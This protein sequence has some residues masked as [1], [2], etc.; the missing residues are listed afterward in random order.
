MNILGL[1]SSRDSH[2]SSAA[3][4]CDGELVAAA[5]EERF[6]RKKHEPGLPA[7]AVKFCLERAGLRMAQVDVVAVAE[8][9]FRTGPSSYHAEMELSFMRRLCAEGKITKRSLVHKI[10]LDQCLSLGIGFNWQMSFAVA[11]SLAEFRE[12]YGDLPSTRF[13]DHHRAHAAAAY[14]TS[15]LDRAS[16]ATIDGY[17]GLCSSV[18]WVALGS[19]F[20]RMHAEPLHNSIG[21]F[22]WDCT[23]YLGLGDFDEG[24]TMGLASYG[25]GQAYARRLSSFLDTNC[26]GWYRY[27]GYLT[28]KLLGFP[29]R[30]SESILQ[31]P[32]PDFAAGAQHLLQRAI[33]KLVHST[34]GE[35]K[36]RA[37][38]LG[39]GV[40]LNCTSNGALLASG[41]PSSVWVFPATSDAGLSVGAAMLCAADA[42]ELRR[43]RMDNSYWGP[44]YSPAECEAAL[45]AA[46]GL[47]FRP[48]SGIASVVTD[49]LVAGNVVGWFQGRMEF[50]PRALGNRSILA[51]P[52]Q[53]K[54]RDRVNKLKGRELWRPLSPVV[55]AE[56]ASEFFDLTAPSPFMLFAT[57]VRPEMRAI[58]PAVVHVDGSARPQTVTREQNHRLYELISAFCQRTDVPV[59]LN[60]SFNAA[61]EPIVC[62]P[63]DAVKTFL[64]TGLDILVLGNYV[65]RR[66]SKSIW[67]ETAALQHC[68]G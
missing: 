42:G 5:E 57:Q 38:C 3:I 68:T 37:L 30:D 55:L 64:A 4:V 8:L 67:G 19:N 59:L 31:E 23:K 29:P 18:S 36:C 61:G 12:L 66:Q 13:Y 63:E 27:C 39:G 25:N 7:H 53:V 62:T 41:V 45:R 58:I 26:P 49:Y 40:A 32:Y 44:E 2:D 33:E 10:V 9:P 22:Y 48:V 17:G 60:T 15:G 6:T 24:K 34:I 54:M 14:F 65:V 1:A 47:V 20:I 21:S 51:D 28:P 52:R 50:G 11:H 43:T 46:S 35:T 16:I 56:R